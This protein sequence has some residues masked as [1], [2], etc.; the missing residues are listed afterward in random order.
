MRRSFRVAYGGLITG[1]SVI[2]MF[3]TGVFPFAEYALPAMAGILLIAMVIEF[4]FKAALIAYAAVALLS[5]VVTPNKEAAVLFIAFLGYY[6]I[7]K[8]RIEMIRTIWLQWVIKVIIFN[9]ALIASYWV[10]VNL[11]G[12]TQVLDDFGMIQNALALLWLIGNAVFILYDVAVTRLISFYVHRFRPHYLK[13][14]Q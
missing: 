14:F 12:M 2:C 9:V 11:L 7:V 6:P 4:G 5:F 3:F 13:R 8:G 10:V 1:L